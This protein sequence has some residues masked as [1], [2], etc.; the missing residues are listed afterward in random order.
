MRIPTPG[1]PVAFLNT[2][3]VLI[4]LRLIHIVPGLLWLGGAALLATFGLPAARAEGSLPYLRRLIWT[5]N[6]PRYLNVT[7]VLALLSA[8]IMYGN[9]VVATGAHGPGRPWAGRSG[10][11]ACSRSLPRRW[12][13][14]APC[15][16]PPRWSATGADCERQ[17]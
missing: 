12:L 17:W 1:S 10:W 6:L 4:T 14:H 8:L 15:D 13:P 9:L 2:K 3:L 11:E 16:L 7:L 5:R